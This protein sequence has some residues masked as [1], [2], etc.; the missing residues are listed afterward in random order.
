MII[1]TGVV[2]STAGAGMAVLGVRGVRGGTIV[3]AL[4]LIGGRA[5]ERPVV[6]AVTRGIHRPAGRRGL[7]GFARL[8]RGARVLAGARRR[9]ETIIGPTAGACGQDRSAEEQ[10]GTQ[11]HAEAP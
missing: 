9:P 8:V 2:L 3:P 4:L 11:A 5:G 1:V 6:R 10:Q 7:W